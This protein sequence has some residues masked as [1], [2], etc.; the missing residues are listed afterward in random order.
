MKITREFKTGVVSVA[1]IALF[2]WGY[3]Y[4]KG[5]N[6]FEGPLNTY[7]A[8]YPNVLGL[9][10]A[11][12]VTLNGVQVGKVLD[13]K[14]LKDKEKKGVVLVE[15][16]ANTDLKFS[17][18]SIAKIYSSSLMGG[19]SM[20]IIPSF[21]GDLAKPGDYLK[22]IIEPDVFASVA[23]KLNPLQ[24]KVDDVL[25]NADALLKNLNNVLDAKTQ[26]NLK[27]SI[28]QLNEVITSFNASSKTINQ[29]LQNNQEKLGNT[30]ANT[31]KIAANLA[32]VTD[33]LSRANLGLV[34][35]NLESSVAN[36]NSILAKIK[37]GEGSLGKLVNDDKMYNNLTTASK[38]LE[39]L[40][41]EV[42]LHPKRFVHFSIFGKK[43]KG[44]ISEPESQ[45]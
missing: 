43:D 23:D 8:E 22:G 25:V 45:Q 10:E 17:K 19:K 4:L 34:V 16:S 1:I 40:L 3:N 26:A 7:Y 38:E 35:K 11:S 5:T 39:E 18:N 13:I 12:V 14:F 6:L 42:K 37:S 30:I 36:I 27:S 29:L 41:R 24:H 21:E 32:K 33:S 15:F 2:I 28:E 9:T 31:D 20:A 44:Y